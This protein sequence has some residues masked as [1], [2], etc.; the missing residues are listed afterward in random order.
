MAN[1][2]QFSYFIQMKTC[3]ALDENLR[4]MNHEIAINPKYL[5]KIRV[6]PE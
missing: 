1:T 3:I 5:H 6:E 2:F 4:K